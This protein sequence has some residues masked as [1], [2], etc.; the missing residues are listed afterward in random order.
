MKEAKD[1]K[2]ASN[3]DRHE[4]N[5]CKNKWGAGAHTETTEF[6]KH[7]NNEANERNNIIRTSEM[8]E[9]REP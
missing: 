2:E 6:D 3:K 4:A 9:R 7:E 5:D 1:R 8:H